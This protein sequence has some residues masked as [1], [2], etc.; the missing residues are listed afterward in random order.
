MFGE[1]ACI[2]TGVP[3]ETCDISSDPHA[4]QYTKRVLTENNTLNVEWFYINIIIFCVNSC[5]NMYVLCTDVFFFGVGVF[6][7]INLKLASKKIRA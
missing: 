6:V 4:H 5:H 3:T 2:W 7:R 1:F